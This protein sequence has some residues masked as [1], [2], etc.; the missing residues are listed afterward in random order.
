AS[1][2]PGLARSIGDA[3]WR[4]ECLGH[5]VRAHQTPDG[6]RN[7]D[8]PAHPHEGSKQSVEVNQ[9]ERQDEADEDRADLDVDR[10]LARRHAGPQGGR[11]QNEADDAAEGEQA[12]AGQMEVEHEEAYTDDYQDQPTQVQWQAVGAD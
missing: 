5:G 8:L 3:S 11:A 2:R 4:D 6:N 12:V 10:L 1:S 9:R 7:R